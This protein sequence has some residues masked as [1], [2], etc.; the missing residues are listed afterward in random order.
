[1]FPFSVFVEHYRGFEH[2]G[3]LR[4]MMSSSVCIENHFSLKPLCKPKILVEIL[5]EPYLKLVCTILAFLVTLLDRLEDETSSRCVY[6]ETSKFSL[7]VSLE[8]PESNPA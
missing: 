3:G 8:N 6:C 1:M 5:F 4:L 2:I 7:G